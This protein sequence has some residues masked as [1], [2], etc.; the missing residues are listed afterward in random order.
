MQAL[1]GTR[2]ITERT[3]RPRAET[4][5]GR[6]LLLSESFRTIGGAPSL[7]AADGDACSI[8]ARR[9]SARARAMMASS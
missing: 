3:T 1:A 8:A 5:G 2:D 7:F 4:A 9:C 6:S